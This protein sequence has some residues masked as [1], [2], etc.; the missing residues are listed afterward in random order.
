[1]PKKINSPLS[2]NQP[3][4]FLS[5]A[6]EDGEDF[7]R[8]LRKKL[9]E[10]EDP[11]QPKFSLWQDRTQMEGGKD[12]WDQ[13][14]EALKQVEYMVLVMT[15]AALVSPIVRKEWRQARQE[16]VGVIPVFGQ[17]DLD[18]SQL[19]RWMRDVHWV[20]TDVPEQWTRFIRTLESPY[21]G[22]RVSFMPDDLPAGFVPRLKEFEELAG[23][24][25]DPKQEEPVAITA[26]LKGA[27][28]YGK[29]TLAKALC[30]DERIQHA[31]HDG[32]LWVTLGEQPNTMA[33]LTKL[34]APLTEERPNF[35][36]EED[37]LA[38]LAEVLGD[39]DCLMVI[40]DVWNAAHLRPFLRGG[41]R[42]ARI[43]TTRDS[44]TLPETARLRVPVD[45]MQQQ[46][47]LALL[48]FDL[49][50]N[51]LANAETTA[52]QSLAARL[53]GWPF[54]L[55]L[56]NGALRERVNTM[57]QPLPAALVYVQKA[58]EKRGLT[59]FDARNPVERN[60]A[61]AATLTASFEHLKEDEL[62]RYQELAIFPED[63]E[64]PLMAIAKLW[65]ATGGLDDF[66]T[67]E[68]C[69]RLNQLSLL[70]SYDPTTQRIQ[71]HD[72]VRTYLEEQ[73]ASHLPGL[74][75]QF[76]DTYDLKHEPIK[77]AQDPYLCRYLAYH[78]VRAERWEELKNFLLNV[79][80]LYAKLETLD[81]PALLSDFDWIRSEEIFSVVQGAIRLSAHIVG[82][83]PKQLVGQLLGRLQNEDS[84]EIK[85]LVEKS[86]RW[87]K[88]QWLRPL[89][90]SLIAPG[91]P[92]IR[93]LSGHSALV[94]AIAVTPDG[95]RVIS[96]SYD[97][98]CI[99]WDLA[100][101][102]GLYTLSGHY[103]SVRAVAVTADGIRAI[104]ASQD[105]TC[106][107]WDLMT[108]QKLQTFHGHHGGVNAVAVTP[109]GRWAIS[110]S[111]D[112]TCI[113]WDL[114]TGNELQIFRGHRGWVSA[115]VVTIEGTRAISAS[116]DGTCIV[117]DLHT[118]K[119]LH[120]LRRGHP[121]QVSA[122][123]VMADV[124]R[125]VLAT[126]DQTCIVWD[127][128]TG[129]ELQTL[130]LN[131]ASGRAMAVTADGT[132][133]ILATTDQTCIVCD[134][135]MGLELQTLYGHSGPVTAV[136]V[137]ADGTRAVSASIDWTCKVWDLSVGQEL[138]TLRGHRD[139]VTAVVVTGDGTRA[140][141][142][143][144]DRTCKVW[145]L[146]TGQELHSLCGYSGWVIAVAV[147]LDG[148]QA[149]TV[150][151]DSPCIVW[152]LAT[153]KELQTIPGC[154]RGATAVVLTADGRAVLVS[155]DQTLK[156]WA[157]DTGQELHTLRGHSGGVTAVAVTGDGTRAISVSDDQTCKVWNLGTGQELHTLRGHSDGVTAVAVTADG[158]RAIS[159]SN[160]QTCKV[161]DLGTGQELYTLPGHSGRVTAVA[162]TVDG[163]RAVLASDNWTCKVWDL[164]SMKEVATFIGESVISS[165]AVSPDSKTIIVGERAGRIHIL[166]LE[167]VE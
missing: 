89:Q 12:W 79:D 49:P 28:G 39:K 155:G 91:G 66:D 32:I 122:V 5:Y 59:A 62:V 41:K 127:L 30:H 26:A 144:G 67:E 158:T 36:D 24:L 80:W 96:A 145:D 27:G 117:W 53:G 85:N 51:D 157:L 123:A 103:D 161:W 88:H 153:G 43:I 114:R 99:V 35:V 141:S 90:G 102:Q 3:R 128:G 137:T 108:G 132:R 109:D 19:P 129:Q 87:R 94:N 83:D 42:C 136:A 9:T 33:G 166:R 119:E 48:A 95:T 100:T 97:Q 18:L 55:K 143:S 61:V 14:L 50:A 81:V 146:S 52:L 133:A 65:N 159:A 60:Q 138:Q 82:K 25:L 106:I 1:M 151:E 113:V 160:D 126:T 164:T 134:L 77:S 74:H 76:L 31:F 162:L 63:V 47:A 15:Q 16:G 111:Q 56:V 46:E 167:G 118:G 20:D 140:I 7:A 73:V 130:R 107:V 154:G 152:D 8:D 11:G 156:V 165:C 112:Q 104:S 110:A 38:R 147:T 64:I 68:L 45:A 10:P 22:T 121:G 84:T 115:V 93:T 29:T 92:L 105:G 13:I 2:G 57:R 37:A 131:R 139:W 149:I 124:T 86:K 17:P 34:Y 101:G 4:I 163:M 116:E 98:T 21:Q 71:L 72:V 135:G 70:L 148:T 150:S 75:G 120:T 125:A 54:L 23:S 6:R 69:T 44:C 142:A 40:D 78:L 58:L